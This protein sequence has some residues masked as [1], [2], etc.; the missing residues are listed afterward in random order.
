MT[1]KLLEPR[2]HPST[3]HGSRAVRERH[4]AASTLQ[5]ALRAL[6]IALL[7]MALPQATYATPS[8]PEQVLDAIVELDIKK[9]RELLSDRADAPTL[10]LERA[11]LAMYTGDCE[12]ALAVLSAPTVSATHEGADLLAVATTCAGAT[13]GA[14]TV[15][16]EAAGVHV[17]LQD[18]RDKA[19]VPFIVEVAEKARNAMRR[20]LGVDLPRPL[21][22]DLVR[23]TFSLSA[24]TGLPVTAAE[25]T[26]TLA[27]A[28]YGRVTMISPRATRLGYGWEDTLAHEITHLALARATRDRAPL[29]LQ[30]GIAKREETRWREVRPGDGQPSSE[31]IAYQ[32][33]VD[34]RSV[35][36]DKL[37]QSIAM[38]PTPEAASIAYAEV[39]SFVEYWIAQNGEA[40]LRLLFADLKGLASPTADAA[41]RSVSGYDVTEWNQ[42]WRHHLRNNPPKTQSEPQSTGEALN[43]Q[44]LARWVRLTD[45][46]YD[47][48]HSE[49]ALQAIEPALVPAG[50]VA[51]I[52]WR[53]ARAGLSAGH[54]DRA[55]QLLGGVEEIDIVH[56]AWFALRGR[57]LEQD[58]QGAEATQAYALGL[59]VDPLFDEVACHGRSRREKFSSPSKSEEALCAAARQIVR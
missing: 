29:W 32:A 13:A 57:F 41:L 35:G 4:R 45:L 53:A 40:A 27:V 14:L 15:K 12:A 5:Q 24:V 26:G 19:L 21:R 36:I 34:G 58:R 37:G 23:D 46:L 31:T 25:T 51:S 50:H 11:R 8:H 10:P 7:G 16:D 43:T 49:A 38:L 3:A 59:A 42:K 52:R 30:E 33:M 17:R 1:S 48:G 9:A 56:G 18:S 6:A 54:R 28:R 22:I 20:D 55:R 44:A 2:Q 47:R 39:Q